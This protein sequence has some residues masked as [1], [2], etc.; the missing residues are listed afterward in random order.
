MCQKYIQFFPYKI[1][2]VCVHISNSFY[3]FSNINKDR[4]LE[5]SQI[6][7]NGGVAK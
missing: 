1:K 7:I 4:N 2:Y 3:L 5:L 6:Y